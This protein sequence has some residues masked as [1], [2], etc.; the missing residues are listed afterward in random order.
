MKPTVRLIALSLAVAVNA[1]A[2]VAL[3]VAMVEGADQERVS[4]QEPERIVITA[5]RASAPEQKL[6]GGNCPNPKA[7]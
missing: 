2:L 3:H 6:A 7:L 1:G 5:S 4:L